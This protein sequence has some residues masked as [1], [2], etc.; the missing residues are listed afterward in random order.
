MRDLASTGINSSIISATHSS[1][2]QPTVADS[3]AVSSAAATALTPLM[4]AT[5]G[6]V[7]GPMREV[8]ERS[9]YRLRGP[10]TRPTS[11]VTIFA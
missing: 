7:F 8:G 10:V 2:S 4:R 6:A 3:V 11:N 1:S 5:S 9:R